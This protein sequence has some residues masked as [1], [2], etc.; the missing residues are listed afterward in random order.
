MDQLPFPQG[1]RRHASL[2]ALKSFG[3]ADE[4]GP[5]RETFI[6]SEILFVSLRI[7]NC[8]KCQYQKGRSFAAG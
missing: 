6:R 2:S 5:G 1:R 4:K 3:G 7:D 8:Q